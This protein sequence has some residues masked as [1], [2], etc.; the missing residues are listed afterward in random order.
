[1]RVENAQSCSKSN[2]FVQIVKVLLFVLTFSTHLQ[3][4][5]FSHMFNRI[6]ELTAKYHYV[7]PVPYPM[8]Q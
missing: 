6:V 2:G 4:P 7:D 8:P 1:M 3:Q 5:P